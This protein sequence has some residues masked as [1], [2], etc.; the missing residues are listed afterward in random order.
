MLR[1]LLVDHPV[2]AMWR[3]GE[4]E[5]GLMRNRAM[6]GR[7]IKRRLRVNC[8]IV[9][10]W[11]WHGTRVACGTSG[12]RVAQKTKPYAMLGRGVDKIDSRN[13]ENTDNQLEICPWSQH[14]AGNTVLAEL[15][16]VGKHT[17][18]TAVHSS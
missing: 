7:H 8:A 11:A 13:T 2:P 3:S 12:R 17:L 1:Y 6:A 4:V 9:D 5:R 16:L 18:S 14:A 15:T 10:A